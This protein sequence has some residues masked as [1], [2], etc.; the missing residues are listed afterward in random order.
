MQNDKTTIE[1]TEELRMAIA[2]EV[3]LIHKELRWAHK[4]VRNIYG[5]IGIEAP[6]PVELDDHQL[7]LFSPEEMGG[8]TEKDNNK[9]DNKKQTPER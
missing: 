1:I 2:E 8:T 7:S 4:H 9:D 5:M 6:P 3:R